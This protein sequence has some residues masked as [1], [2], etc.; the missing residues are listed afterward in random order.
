MKNPIVALAV[1]AL[2]AACATPALAQRNAEVDM[3]LPPNPV[4]GEVFAPAGDTVHCSV[5]ISQTGTGS[6]FGISELKGTSD[7][8]EMLLSMQSPPFNILRMDE[9]C[10]I[11]SSWS[12]ASIASSMLGIAY[13]APSDTYWLVRNQIPKSVEEYTMGTGTPTGRTMLIGNTGV[14]GPLCTDDN[15]VD[16]ND[17]YYEDIAKDKIFAIDPIAGTFGCTFANPDNAGNGAFGNGL[18]DAVDPTVCSSGNTNLVVSSGTIGEGQVVRAG[19]FDCS[20]SCPDTWNFLNTIIPAGST[21]V[22]SICE[23]NNSAGQKRM[24]TCDG[25]N[26]FFYISRQSQGIS[27]CQGVDG[28]SLLTI[29]FQDG[30][31]SNFVISIGANNPMTLRSK[32]PAAGGNG[33]FV[34]YWHAGCPDETTINTLPAALGPFCH[35][36]LDVR[37][38]VC[39]W[40]N[41]GKTDR[42]GASNYFGTPV[43]DPAKAPS[44]I[45]QNGPGDPTNM[46]QG[47][48]W[49]AQGITRNPGASSPRAASVTNALQIAIQ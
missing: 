20:N 7:P 37:P 10:N 33:K 3:Y 38:E 1:L 30:S 22:Q 14:P 45:F 34:F 16:P 25:N 32:K 11:L 35:P 49:T 15:T 26:N 4:E 8:V 48:F 23:F 47:T 17:F 9:D 44:V 46:P 29:N 24:A 42:L 41:I 28:E 12:T 40:N 6:V 39:V 5:Q 13:Y 27:N 43:P 19:Q 21:F 31:G 2:C 36:M 18:D